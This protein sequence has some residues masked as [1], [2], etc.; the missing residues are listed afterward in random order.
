MIRSISVC[1]R[2]GCEA[3]TKEEKEKQQLA[4]IH[5]GFNVIHGY[6]SSGSVKAAHNL[7]SKSWCLECRKKL[8]VVQKKIQ[9]ARQEKSDNIPSLEDMV[10]EIVRE[11]CQ[12]LQEAT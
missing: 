11:E 2:C 4:E 5:L 12:G 7:W 8:G 9:Q 3:E 6:Y 10:R 1:D